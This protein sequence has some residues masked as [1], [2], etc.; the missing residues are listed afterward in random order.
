MKQET[1][2]LQS[3][4]QR[5]ILS[6]LLV[7]VFPCISMAQQNYDYQKMLIH[8]GNIL[9][10]FQTE[11]V[12]EIKPSKKD[13]NDNIHPDVVSLEVLGGND[14]VYRYPL[15]DIDSITFLKEK[16]NQDD[17]DNDGSNKADRHISP[18]GGSLTINVHT[19]KT[20]EQTFSTDNPSFLQIEADNEKGVA[21]IT[22][23]PNDDVYGR[24]ATI[25]YGD[26][27]VTVH[28]PGK[29][30]VKS[31]AFTFSGQGMLHQTDTRDERGSWEELG[32]ISSGFNG[33]NGWVNVSCEREG[34]NI[35]KIKGQKVGQQI[36]DSN[37]DGWNTPVPNDEISYFNYINTNISYE[38]YIDVTTSP[39]KL[40]F[41]KMEGSS[42]MGMR[43][44]YSASDRQTF[45]SY[46]FRVT[47]GSSDN[48]DCDYMA[49]T[50]SGKNCVH[51]QWKNEYSD[52]R[53]L[54]E[55]GET[56][57]FETTTNF[58]Y[59][60]EGPEYQEPIFSVAISTNAIQ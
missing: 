4:T 8:E 5:S 54:N 46:E 43:T 18:E 55:A 12:K 1:I 41:A 6:L 20:D 13:I 51:A 28:Q 50:V 47:G 9:V 42:V 35:I 49:L 21:V 36:F 33:D 52:Y 44:W 2:N 37:T 60:P 7:I 32:N 39:G 57:K 27:T 40:I 56:S 3:S 24:I 29:G 38:A 10:S 59:F 23:E 48:K 31:A 14:A 30:I 19:T 17:N 16:K 15:A 11:F 58:L 45:D 26:A 53:R 25:N 34:S 22:V